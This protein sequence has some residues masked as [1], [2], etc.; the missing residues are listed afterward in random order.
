MHAVP[1]LNA[2]RRD[3]ESRDRSLHRRDALEAQRFLHR[4]TGPL[5]RR[6]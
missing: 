2:Q 1:L 6:H 5:E 4:R 3:L